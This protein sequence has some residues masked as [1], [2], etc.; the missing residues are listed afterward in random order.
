MSDEPRRK[1]IEV[2][3]PLEAISVASRRDKDRKTGTIKN[4]HKWF[5]PMPTPAWRALLFASLVADPEDHTRRT[6]LLSLIE[7]LVPGDGSVPDD[8]TLAE[9]RAVIAAEWPDGAPVVLDP[10][11]GGG[12]TLI[13]AQRL[14]LDGVGSDLNPV[15]VLITRVLTE[16]IP[17]TAGRAPLH[18]IDGRLTTTPGHPVEGLIADINVYA[19]RV[20]DAAWTRVGHLY[21]QGPKGGLVTA[22]LWARTVTCPN[23]ACGCMTPLVSS[24]W[25]TKRKSAPKWVEPIVDPSRPVVRFEIHSSGTAPRAGTVNRNGARCVACDAPIPFDYIRAEGRV[26][27]MRVQLLAL[28]TDHDG[29]RSYEP[30]CQEQEEASRVDEP[31][32]TPDLPLPAQALG[33]RIQSYGLT[34]FADLFTSRQLHALMAFSDSTAKV[35]DWVIADVGDADY[36]RTIASVLGLCVGKLA[37]SNSSQVRWYIDSRNG[38][39]Q[40]LPAFGRNALPMIW[41]FVE[42]NPFGGSVGDWLGQVASVSRGLYAL[43]PGVKPGHTMQLTRATRPGPSRRPRS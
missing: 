29:S 43:P 32:G 9:A 2:A 26:G 22:W 31:D 17:R 16:L 7:R 34:R 6:E 33:F 8:H 41:D 19:E 25:I 14:G 27:R 21:P 42:T 15:P 23:P 1:L 40:P 30:P 39:G 5:A 24:F 12:S 35:H 20:R 18:S 36:A 3:L 37:Q 10:F 11:C 13:E 38:A 28:A 4:V